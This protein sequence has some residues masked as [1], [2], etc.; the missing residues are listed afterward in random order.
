MPMVS[1]SALANGL[2]ADPHSDDLLAYLRLHLEDKVKSLQGL[3]LPKPRTDAVGL[4][5]D[6]KWCT[7]LD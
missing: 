4:Q 1:I 2:A 3:T 7:H 5:Y 6:L